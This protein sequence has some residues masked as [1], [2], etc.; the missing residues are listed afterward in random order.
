MSKLLSIVMPTFN[1]AWILPYS[2]SLIK[3]QIVRN[4]DDVEL[5]ICNNAATDDT[6]SVLRGLENDGWFRFINYT[7]HKEIGISISR[8]IDN[9]SGKYFLLWGDDDIPNPRMVDIL[10]DALK[11][12]PDIDGIHFNRMQGY[13]DSSLQ[14][15]EMEN[16]R[17]FYK[18]IEEPEIKY[19]SSKDF[20]R[21]CFRG[22]AFLSV[23]LLSREAWEK[24]KQIYT[25][26][27]LGF[28]FLAPFL[29]GLSGK[30]CLYISYPLC[31]QRCL[32]RP[33]YR[34]KWPAYLYVGIPR[35][36]KDLEKHDVIDGWKE[37]YHIFTSNSQFRSSFVGY[38]NNIVY[39]ATRDKKYYAPLVNE[40][41]QSQDSFFRKL[42]TYTIYLPDWLNKFNRA[43]LGM[44]LKAI[45][46]E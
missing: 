7:D 30:K 36:L 10:V 35:A 32:K 26:D 40:I 44:F 16:L 19:E 12:Y 45:G 3:D 42:V 39:W 2:L 43:V 1:R 38:V 27:H 9:A 23:N 17:V 24:G 8:S 13:A 37:H 4:A 14:Q 5:I 20:A 28:E 41:N 18:T 46:K 15:K 33:I 31:I 25:A 6:E 22:M 34:E 29:Y 11:R 21:N